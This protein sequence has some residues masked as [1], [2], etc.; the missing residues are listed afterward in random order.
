LE[1]ALWLSKNSD[2]WEANIQ[3]LKLVVA[4]Q[5]DLLAVID[6]RLKAPQPNKEQLAWERKHAQQKR[7]DERQEAKIGQAGLNSGARL[8][9]TPT[10][11]L[12]RA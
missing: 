12:A 5:P 7:E 10:R 6:Q 4:D 2:G 3:E 9:I 8:P 1:A 11:L